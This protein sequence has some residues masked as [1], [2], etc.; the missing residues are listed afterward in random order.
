MFDVEELSTV[1]PVVIR[2]AI[3]W[4][5][6]QGGGAFHHFLPYAVK[7]QQGNEKFKLVKMGA[8]L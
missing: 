2:W 5:S 6:F 8:E 3:C 7:A 4:R 1:I